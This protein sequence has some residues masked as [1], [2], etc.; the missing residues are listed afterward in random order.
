MKKRFAIH[1]VAIIASISFAFLQCSS[2]SSK[3]NEAE[4]TPGGLVKKRAASGKQRKPKQNEKKRAKN[5]KR[6]SGSMS[7]SDFPF[8]DDQVTLSASH[9]LIAYKGALRASISVTRTK[10]EALSMAKEA[11]NKIKEGADFSAVAKEYSDCPSR[12]AGGNLGTFRAASMVPQFSKAVLALEEGQVSEPVTSPS[13]YHIIKRYELEKVYTRHILVMHNGIKKK[14]P[15]INRT[16]KEA[17]KLIEEVAREIRKPKADFVILANKYSD[18]MSKQCGGNLKP[19]G[20]LGVLPAFEKAV[21]ALKDW[22]LSDIV[23]TRF[24]YHIIQRIPL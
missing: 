11:F 23:E 19:I 16:K 20:R 13:G 24:G 8:I 1:T 14:P 21:F 17:R 15:E 5:T 18:C 9:I 6:S 12:D 4:G 10:G 3:K 2:K 7:E 22:E